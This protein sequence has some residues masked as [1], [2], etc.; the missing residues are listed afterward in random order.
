MNHFKSILTYFFILHLFSCLSIE[1]RTVFNIS[2]NH[3]KH[4]HLENT[5]EPDNKQKKPI[6]QTDIS[7]LTPHLADES[8]I[9]FQ[10]TLTHSKLNFEASTLSVTPEVASRISDCTYSPP[11]P[12]PV[13]MK[14]AYKDFDYQHPGQESFFQFG[15]MDVN[16]WPVLLGLHFPEQKKEE[17]TVVLALRGDKS[18]FHKSSFTSSLMDYVKKNKSDNYVLFLEELLYNDA[19]KNISSSPLMALCH[20]RSYPMYGRIGAGWPAM[21]GGRNW[22]LLE[23]IFPENPMYE[24]IAYSNGTYPRFEFIRRSVIKGFSE[25]Y[26]NPDR[27]SA[28]SFL[29]R[30]IQTTNISDRRTLQIK[31]IIDIEGNYSSGKP[32]WD[33]AAF[34]K[35]TIEP[36]YAKYYYS[37]VRVN[38]FNAYQNNVLLIQALE[39][40]GQEDENGIIRYSN[41]NGNIIF[42]VVTNIGEPHYFAHQVDLTE[43]TDFQPNIKAKR[44]SVNHGNIVGIGLDRFHSTKLPRRKFMFSHSIDR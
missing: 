40:K 37:I 21:E 13:P 24:I 44:M 18:G 38:E 9:R 32:I 5:P 10:E 33:L 31:G 7:I 28:S 6:P 16:S 30:Y 2:L 26:H 29:E 22:K 12:D 41:E 36:D 25:M 14:I 3:L 39:L 35:E 42:D 1:D 17:Q 4:F 34:L 43:K 27:E 11:V 8:T 23:K 15:L 19:E 20:Y